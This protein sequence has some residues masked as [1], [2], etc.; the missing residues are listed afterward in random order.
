M[1]FIEKIRKYIYIKSLVILLKY[2]GLILP[3]NKVLKVLTM[4]NLNSFTPELYL[5]LAV[6][7]LSLVQDLIEHYV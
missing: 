5:I 6:N 2:I 4:I 7:T 3:Q 1:L